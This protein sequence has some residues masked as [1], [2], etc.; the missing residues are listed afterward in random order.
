[1]FVVFA[2]RVFQTKRC[3]S[4]EKNDEGPGAAL[5]SKSWKEF[6]RPSMIQAP[7]L[8]V[9][10]L[11]RLFIFVAGSGLPLSLLSMGQSLSVHRMSTMLRYKVY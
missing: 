9:S 2:Q 10:S 11:S 7:N 1:M 5:R 3:R 8:V 6:S 4:G